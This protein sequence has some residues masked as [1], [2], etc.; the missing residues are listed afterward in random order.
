M[1][2]IL[3][4][5]NC[6]IQKIL[7]ILNINL[8]NEFNITYI[9]CF[10]TNITN[11]DFN[12]ILKNAD[13]IITQP[14]H[15]NYREMY[16]L[17]SN[18]IINNSKKE[19]VIIFVN[20]CHFDFYYF[21]LIYNTSSKKNKCL[22]YHHSSIIDCINNYKDIDY[23]EKVYIENINLKK[24]Y[25]LDEIYNISIKELEKRYTEMLQYSKNN[26]YFINIL[27]YIK[28]N[29]KDKL[30]FYTFNHPSKYLL[31][32][33]AL[34]IV[35]ILKISNNINY[36]LDPFSYERY[37]LYK[38][39]QKKVNFNIKNHIPLVNNKSSVKEIYDMTLQDISV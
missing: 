34:E 28:N 5:G 6:Q 39:I 14:I 2:N 29:Y 27:E 24:D 23:Y 3:F 35:K 4:Y 36:N 15:D 16:Y 37:I 17:S 7:D 32:Y 12:N 26:T 11:L 8:S 20:N 18:Y 31:Q 30:L 25:E 33:I 22:N 21:D 1:K 13:I 9:E 19:S 38:C 10:S